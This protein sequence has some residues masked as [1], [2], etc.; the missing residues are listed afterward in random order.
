MTSRDRDSV[1]SKLHEIYTCPKD[2]DIFLPKFVN[3]GFFPHWVSVCLVDGL[4]RMGWDGPD[5][6]D[7]MVHIGMIPFFVWFK[8]FEKLGWNLFTFN[9][10][11]QLFNHS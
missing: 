11:Q 9:I 6:G 7:G 3:K 2:I 4:G 5:F 10:K 1:K 8:V